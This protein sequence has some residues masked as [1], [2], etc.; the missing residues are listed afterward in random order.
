MLCGLGLLSLGAVL[1]LST[2]G[3][4]WAL[5][6]IMVLVLLGGALGVYEHLTGNFAFAQEVNATAASAAPLRVAF[7]GA[8][9]LGPR[10]AR[11]FTAIVALAAT[12]LGTLPWPADRVP[13]D[14]ANQQRS[15]RSPGPL[16]IV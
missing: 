2:A 9:P 14:C 12:Y 11:R 4:I 1:L 8:N 5:R 15:R 7:T 16:L 3:D 13:A 6:V 10:R